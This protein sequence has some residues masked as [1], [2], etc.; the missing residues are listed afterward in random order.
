MIYKT[1][2]N[3]QNKMKKVVSILFLSSFILQTFGQLS[4]LEELDNKVRKYAKEA[5]DR[6]EY[7]RIIV[8]SNNDKND[9]VIYSYTCG[10]LFCI[11]VFLNINGQYEEKLYGLY[12]YF[13]LY[14]FY[15]KKRLHLYEYSCCGESPFFSNKIYEFNKTSAI[16]VEDYIETNDDYV[17][18]RFLKP[19]KYLYKSYSVKIFNDDYN[20]RF[21]PDMEPFELNDD[22]FFTC[23]T[24]T[25][26][27]AKIKANS[28]VKVLAEFKTK[29]RKWLYVEVEKQSIKDKCRITDFES[30]AIR[31]WISGNY[32][33]KNN[34]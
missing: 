10:E 19:S 7:D 34:L 32:V 12:S 6:E 15:D 14:S 25:N 27:I 3:L 24:K 23:D 2:N 26:I 31:G 21:S 28:I 17:E 29:E 8:D 33:E 4:S 11:R 5:F 1:I 30:Q 9:D 13:S 18:N 20:L 16:L 22:I